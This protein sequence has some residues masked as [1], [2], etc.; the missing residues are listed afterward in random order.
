M[1]IIST[2]RRV[3]AGAKVLVHRHEGHIQ[4]RVIYYLMNIH[5]LPR[6]IYLTRVNIKF[7]LF[8]CHKIHD[9]LTTRIF[10][11]F[12]LCQ[13]FSTVRVAIT[14]KARSVVIL[15]CR[16]KAGI[17]PVPWAISSRSNAFVISRFGRRGWNGPFKRPAIL[18]HRKNA[19][20]LSTKSTL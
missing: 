13:N 8:F 10:I 12:F 11:F 6:T 17:M 9:C 1:A 19:G 18:K 3:P 14:F 7:I 15:T 2:F 16:K 5:I 20:R 4:S